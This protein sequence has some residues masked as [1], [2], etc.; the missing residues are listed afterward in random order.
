LRSS[1]PNEDSLDSLDHSFKVSDGEHIA[2]AETLIATQFCPTRQVLLPSLRETSDGRSGLCRGAA[3]D[4][5]GRAADA[6]YSLERP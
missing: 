5:R 2:D 4:S 1:G 6:E 3:N